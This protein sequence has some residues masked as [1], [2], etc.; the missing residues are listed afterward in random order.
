M[1]KSKKGEYTLLEK[2]QKI[3]EAGIQEVQPISNED[4]LVSLN[5]RIQLILQIIKI[6]PIKAT[7]MNYLIMYDI[8][9]NKVR[10]QISKYLEKKGCVRI[11]KSVFLAKTENKYFQEIHDTLKEVNSYYD[12]ADSII[13]V[14]INASD[15]RSMKL[16]GKNVNIETITDKPN[17]LFF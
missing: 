17:T 3:K 2:L 7:Q 15:V 9:E 5:E 6:Q 8:T 1:A 11:Q 12:N 14:P 16:I 4:Q 13:L 10:Y